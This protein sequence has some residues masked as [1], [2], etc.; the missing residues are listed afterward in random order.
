MSNERFRTTR[1]KAVALDFLEA[2]W[3]ADLDEAYAHLTSDAKFFVAPSGAD[4]REQDARSMLEFLVDKLFSRFH[5]NHPLKCEITSMIQEHDVVATEYVA[6][7]KTFRL[8]PY[9]NY[10]SAH[11]VIEDHLV[12]SISTY[13]DTLYMKGLLSMQRG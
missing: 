1:Q 13:G 4:V 11:L 5:E 3:R 6:R 7:A 9:E 10:Y 12:R 2:F 8:E